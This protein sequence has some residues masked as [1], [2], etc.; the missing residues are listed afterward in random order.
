MTSAADEAEKVEEQAEAWIKASFRDPDGNYARF[1]GRFT[2]GNMT[3]AF[4]AGFAAGLEHARKMFRTPGP[5]CA[6]CGTREGLRVVCEGWGVGV[7]PDY[8]CEGCFTGTD[9][10]PCFDDLPE[11]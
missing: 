8:R 5:E 7:G 10:G 1:E 3:T 9:T 6:F 2:A 4:R 11:A